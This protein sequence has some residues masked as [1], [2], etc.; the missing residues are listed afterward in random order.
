M[1][2]GWRPRST[3][4]GDKKKGGIT[5]AQGDVTKRTKKNAAH[6]MGPVAIP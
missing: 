1:G 6:P 2:G 5:L 4:A 3:M